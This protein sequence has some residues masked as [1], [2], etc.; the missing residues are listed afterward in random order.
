VVDRCEYC[1]CPY[2]GT[3]VL[4]VLV[5]K[6]FPI[7]HCQL[8]RYPKTRDNVLPE[9]FCAIFVV[10]METTLASIHLVKYSTLKG[11]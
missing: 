3:K 6:L 10:M 7:V 4:E 8:G 9:N 1:L 5:V 2:G 11:N